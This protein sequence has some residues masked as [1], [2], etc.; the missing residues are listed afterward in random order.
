MAKMMETF[1]KE[2]TQEMDRIHLVDHPL[3]Q[4]IGRGELGREQFGIFAGHWY[5]GIKDAPRYFSAMHANCP[6]PVARACILENLICEETTLAGGSDTHPELMLRF[7]RALGRSDDEVEAQPALQEN[8]DLWRWTLET[9]LRNSFQIGVT[10]TGL[11]HEYQFPT[12]YRVIVKALREQFEMTDDEIE[13]WIVHIKGDEGHS[14]SALNLVASY[15]KTDAV[16]RQVMDA[17]R[18]SRRRLFAA[19]DAY[20]RECGVVG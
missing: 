12:T 20:A 13:F 3:I 6:E 2:L 8:E 5:R 7:C 14:D 4:A 15:T 10:V 19:F 16:R 18:E 17:L 1:K 11:A 9:C